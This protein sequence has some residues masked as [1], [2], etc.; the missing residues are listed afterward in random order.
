MATSTT[1]APAGITVALRE[2]LDDVITNI[3]PYDTVFLSNLSKTKVKGKYVEWLIDTLTTAGNNAVTEGM[4]ASVATIRAQTR[5][6][7]YCQISAKW[8]AISDT[9]EAVDKAGRKS[10]IA[11]QTSLQLKELACDMC[12]GLI[13]NAVSSSSDPR[14]AMGLKGWL[15]TNVTNFTTGTTSAL[16]TETKFNDALA[17][18]WTQGGK[19]DMVLAPAYS[20]RK[21]SSFTGNSKLTTTIPA[22]ENKVIL[23][24]DYYESDFGVVK[25]YASRFIATDDSASYE[26]LFILE[27][28]KFQLGTLKPVTVEKL[29]KTGLSQ[30][31]QISTE[32]TLISRQEAAS[33]RIKNIYNG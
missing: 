5:K 9:L 14:S 18:C 20:K 32:Y 12:Y 26:S 1:G 13:N 29:A 31:V 15:T 27:K 30:K 28:A 22:D 23:A 25:V 4:D 10:E 16:L 8:F 11:Y 6:G 21:I 7:N 17:A 19:P 24:V 3:A 2:Q 33:T